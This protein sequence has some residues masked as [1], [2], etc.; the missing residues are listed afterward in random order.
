MGLFFQLPDAPQAAC[1]Q[2]PQN[3]GDQS[4]NEQGPT[5]KEQTCNQKNR[6]DP[7]GEVVLAPYDQRVKGANNQQ[8]RRADCDPLKVQLHKHHPGLIIPWA[9][10]E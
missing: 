6:P 1:P 4:L 8:G 10:R 2:K 7:L 9:G 5:E 3:N